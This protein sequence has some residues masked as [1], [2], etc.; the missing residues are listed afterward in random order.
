LTNPLPLLFL[1]CRILKIS[2]IS[3][4][5]SPQDE[6]EHGNHTSSQPP[7]KK[8]GRA[9]K[10]EIIEDDEQNE[11][12]IK[13]PKHASRNKSN[14]PKEIQGG[15]ET[16]LPPP[17][18]R[19]GK[20]KKADAKLD[21]ERL[22]R[23]EEIN[24]PFGETGPQPKQKRP[25][26]RAAASYKAIDDQSGDERESDMP[27]E[28]DEDVEVEPTQSRKKAA[29]ASSGPK[30]TASKKSTKVGSANVS[31]PVI[32]QSINSSPDPRPKP[33]MILKSGFS[34]L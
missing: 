23:Q 15:S 29:K 7:P 25:Q 1:L 3:T 21:S 28:Q 34:N 2:R 32:L 22:A 24:S 18:K 27:N 30:S 6:D 16:E 13:K 33:V 17:P 10:E 31:H 11:R 14:N 8:R 26:R 12:P 4:D 20:G 9:K 19:Q 5:L